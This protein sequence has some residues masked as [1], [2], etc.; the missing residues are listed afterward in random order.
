MSAVAH[1]AYPLS[2]LQQ[3]M[4]S[5]QSGHRANGVDLVQTV[6]ILPEMLDAAAFELAWQWLAQRHAILRTAFR[7]DDPTLPPVQEVQPELALDFTWHDWRQLE[8]DTVATQW[9]ELLAADRARGFDLATAP[10]WRVTVVQ[11]AERT[12][13]VLFSFHHLLLD[14]RALVVLFQELFAALDR[15]QAGR[16][17][18]AAPATPYRNYIDWFEAQD[19]SA[20]IAYWREA[21]AGFR[22]PTPLPAVANPSHGA[23][24]EDLGPRESELTLSAARTAT[25]RTFAEAERVTLNTLVQGAWALLLSR[26]SGE[27]DVLFGAVRACRHGSVA[28]AENIV[29]LLINTVPVRVK[30][31]SAAR[32]GDWLRELRQQWVAL[33]AHEHVPLSAVR[34]LTAVP[35]DTPLFET[36]VS[37]QEPSWDAALTAQGGAW[38]HRKFEV[39][40]GI[41]HPL[42]LDAAGGEALQLRIS[43]DASRYTAAAIERMLGH[44][45]TLLAGMA[46]HPEHSL[47]ELPMLSAGEKRQLLT[48]WNIFPTNAETE[49]CVH[50]LFEQ[51]AARDPSAL[52]VA[53]ASHRLTYG[54]LDRQAGR[55]ARQ[56]HRHGVGPNVFV[57]VCLDSSVELVVALLAVLKAGGAYVPLDPAYPEERLSFMVQDARM[58]VLLTR[59]KFAAIFAEELVEVILVDAPAASTA[60]ESPAAPLSLGSPDDLAYLIYTSGSTGLPKGVPIR[61]R[62]VTNLI[63]WHQRAYEVT[64][65]DRATQLASPAFDACVWE[66]WPYLTAGAS[67]HIPEADVRISPTRLVHWLAAQRI[68][69]CF[70]P[71]PLAEATLDEIW[72]ADMPLRAVL[73]GGDRLRRWPGRQLPCV[74]ANHYGP[75]ESTVVATWAPVPAEADGHATPS[76][77]RPVENTELYVLDRHQRPV[78]VGVPGEL[79]LG[80]AQ[81]ADGYHQRPELTAEKFVADPF[82]RTPGRKLYRTGDLVRWRE[83]GQLDYL[84]RLDQ[85]VKIRGHR[86]EPG[87]IETVLNEHPAVRESLVIARNDAAGQPQLVAYL[88]ARPGLTPPTAG[89]LA[90]TLHRLLPAYMVPVSYVFLESWPLTPN[91]KVDRAALP[92]PDQSAREQ[93]SIAPRAGLE[94]TVAAIWSEVLGHARVGAYDDFFQLG[95][96]S[97]RAAQ[98]V[99][100]L[101]AA[102]NLSLSVRHLFEHST[103]AGLAAAIAPLTATEPLPDPAASPELAQPCPLS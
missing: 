42:A 61:H 1:P 69:L 16:E 53:D 21:L 3:G 38:S 26:C 66:L 99:S 78:P 48:G 90:E 22:T 19:F 5:H 87:E 17:P 45:A 62:N 6:A 51:Q 73:T 59:Q 84:G 83:D 72:P 56:L 39:H 102:L 49:L 14:G 24:S 50:H 89:L 20:S 82:H 34:P 28:G 35:A 27:D 9:A 13:R 65:A 80:G 71:T 100:R 77:G 85:Q 70:L 101:N 25:L 44:L 12:H 95:G 47:V 15:L 86:I 91:G 57:G 41:N 7:W 81:L 11:E 74:L 64:P 92:A 88:L 52:A 60:P 97:L 29:G 30:V 8:A 32:V 58:P 54:E 33:R 79:Y 67:I 93:Q 43:Y 63:A 2:P 98:V 31:D 4:L 37:Y 103:V 96:H 36:I 18:A 68:T 76:I 23:A 55:L 94:T 10:L 75:T 46:A 40:S